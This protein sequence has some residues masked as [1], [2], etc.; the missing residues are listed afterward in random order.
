MDTEMWQFDDMI[1]DD[2]LDNITKELARVSGLSR[3]QR[4]GNPNAREADMLLAVRYLVTVSKNLVRKVNIMSKEIETLR[5]AKVTEKGVKSASQAP[6][7]SQSLDWNKIASKPKNIEQA[8]MQNAI[9]SIQKEVVKRETNVVLHGVVIQ[10]PENEDNVGDVVQSKVNEVFDKIEIDR[11]KIKSVRLIKPKPSQANKS[12]ATSSTGS[13]TSM[14]IIVEL[15]SKNDVLPVLRAASKLKNSE[16]NKVYINPD[17]TESERMEMKN[18]VK[19]RFELNEKLRKENLYNQPFRWVIR[20][21]VVVKFRDRL[22]QNQ[23]E[24]EDN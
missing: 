15:V 4:Q 13:K 7:A 5:S 12:V 3:I 14:P 18:L 23:E 22:Q 9:V 24:E 10:L 8:R 11:S 20:G 21:N 19:K 17:R 2:T 1:P 16:L 6:N